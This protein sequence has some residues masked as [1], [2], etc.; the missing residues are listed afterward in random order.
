CDGLA[1]RICCGLM[2]ML[3]E[4]P[5]FAA[6]LHA[7]EGLPENDSSTVS[8]DYR[9]APGDRL[10]IR[11]FDQD[12]RSGDFLSGDFFVDGSGGI[13]LPLAGTVE[14]TGLSLSEAQQLIQQ[15]FADGILVRPAVSLRLPEFRKIFV[16]GYVKKPGSY[17]FTFGLTVKAAIATA[18][19]E[20]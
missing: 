15:R 6:S 13:L 16:T 9:L 10:K 3:V 7:A 12:Q 8:E 11:V 17:P 1:I 4:L 19:G 20:G 2:L 14:V 18:G 5:T